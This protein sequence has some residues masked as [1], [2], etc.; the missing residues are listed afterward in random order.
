MSRRPG[1]IVAT[2]SR[3][4]T[5]APPATIAAAN[6]AGLTIVVGTPWRTANV[7]PLTAGDEPDEGRR[8]TRREGWSVPIS[9][10][11]L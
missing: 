3:L 11:R 7:P 8:F 9:C 1:V 6:C 2:P 10:G 5:V 4:R